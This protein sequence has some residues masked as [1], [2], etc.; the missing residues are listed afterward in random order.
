MLRGATAKL[1]VGAFGDLAMLAW[2]L[3]DQDDLSAGVAFLYLAVGIPDRV[4]G[5]GAGDRQ[6]E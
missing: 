6:F 3:R 2:P 1:M 5:V 4:E